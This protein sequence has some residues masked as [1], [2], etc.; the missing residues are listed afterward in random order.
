MA[1]APSANGHLE[2]A[3]RREGVGTTPRSIRDGRG[4]FVPGHAG[5]SPGNPHA[6]QVSRLRAA[7]LEAVTPEDLRAIVRVLIRMARK[8]S[9]PAI[10][11]LFERVLGKPV[12]LD[13]LARI[14]EMENRLEGRG[15]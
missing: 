13:I 15:P 12:E 14:E 2:G 6:A 1:E 11:E 3:L 8:G 7:L 9:L 4:R 10:K 5:L